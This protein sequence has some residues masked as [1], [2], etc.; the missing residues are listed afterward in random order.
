MLSTRCIEMIKCSSALKKRLE[1]GPVYVYGNSAPSV[2]GVELLYEGF[3]PNYPNDG[4][5][6][7]IIRKSEI[8]CP[9]PEYNEEKQAKEL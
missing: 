6:L 4:R 8:I 7:Y 5:I 2:S 9:I 1:D 3:L